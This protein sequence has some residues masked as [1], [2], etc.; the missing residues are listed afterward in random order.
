[1]QIAMGVEARGDCVV[2]YVQEGAL[3]LPSTGGRVG[4]L[5]RRGSTVH[6]STA[7]HAID[8]PTV[9]EEVFV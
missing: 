8:S 4:R 6:V 9:C 2:F 5:F 1:M 3:R 7:P